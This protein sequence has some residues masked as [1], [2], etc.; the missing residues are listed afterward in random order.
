MGLVGFLVL[1]IFLEDKL[2]VASEE[3]ESVWEKLSTNGPKLAFHDIA[4]LGDTMYAFGGRKDA[5]FS[6]A[7]NDLWAFSIKTNAWNKT[8][9]AT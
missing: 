2:V 7:V 5:T 3:T 4:V 1:L 8:E 9:P 6:T